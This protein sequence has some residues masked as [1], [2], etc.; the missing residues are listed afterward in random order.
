MAMNNFQRFPDSPPEGRPAQQGTDPLNPLSWPDYCIADL[1]QCI[2]GGFPI[3]PIDCQLDTST[4]TLVCEG[5]Y[6]GQ[7]FV[8]LP[9]FAYYPNPEDPGVSESCYPY[10]C[11]IHRVPEIEIDGRTWLY[12]EVPSALTFGWARVIPGGSRPRPRPSATP[13]GRPPRPGV[14]MPDPRP[15]SIPLIDVTG[16]ARP[17]KPA[18]PSPPLPG[19][20]KFNG[21]ALEEEEMP[22]KPYLDNS[23]SSAG[24]VRPTSSGGGVWYP[25]S[26]DGTPLIYDNARLGTPSAW[27][28]P[29]RLLSDPIYYNVSSDNRRAECVPV[30]RD[31]IVNPP[32]M[33]RPAMFGNLPVPR[34]T[35]FPSP[36]GGGPTPSPYSPDRR[37]PP[38]LVPPSIDQV[39]IECLEEPL[40]G[41]SAENYRFPRNQVLMNKMRW[42]PNGIRFIIH[43]MG[44]GL[45]GLYI[46]DPEDYNVACAS[47]LY[48]KIQGVG[49]V[50]AQ[51][52]NVSNWDARLNA[53]LAINSEAGFAG[54][55]TFSGP[56]K[57]V[58]PLIVMEESVNAERET[59][60][61]ELV[62]AVPSRD[63][64]D[65]KVMVGGVGSNLFLPSVLLLQTASRP[66]IRYAEVRSADIPFKSMTMLDWCER[67]FMPTTPEARKTPWNLG[68]GAYTSGDSLPMPGPMPTPA[69]G[70]TMPGMPD[71]MPMPVPMTRGMNFYGG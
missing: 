61:G 18:L 43:A 25:T 58:L 32:T 16:K 70:T 44:R 62:L 45:G 2:S 63:D 46:F 49:G 40:W 6:N 54:R 65:L 23:L 5:P 20:F 55:M 3:L 8:R 67:E 38:R 12:V 60:T 22:Q 41:L 36:S 69:P 9:S 33:R 53:D 57:G 19:Q 17:L 21:M 11:R 52:C 34:P 15:S 47:G 39:M 64:L 13:Q 35:P 68:G 51:V 26:I 24:C 7:P 42:F 4:D 48:G 27:C 10:F 31:P 37:P 1:D 66:V 28:P 30:C 56:F 71:D 14:P 29:R 50:S 59:D